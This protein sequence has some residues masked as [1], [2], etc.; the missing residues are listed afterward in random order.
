M[1]RVLAVST[2]GYYAWRKRPESRRRQQN[3]RL[4][5]EIKAIHSESRQTY[6]S[7]RIHDELKDRGIR[8]GKK[9]V[10]RLMRL[11]GIEA[12]QTRRFKATTDSKHTLPVAEN[13]LSRQFTPSA[14]DG[15]WSADISVPQQAA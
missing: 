8:C 3:R 11:H 13:V 12:K 2:S 10:A 1:C 9:R 4:V 14:P 6:G 15:V 7:P 5:V